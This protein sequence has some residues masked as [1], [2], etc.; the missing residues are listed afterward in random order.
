M[1]PAMT[2]LGI[3]DEPAILRGYG[4]IDPVTAARLTADATSWRRILTDPI[5][6]RILQ[7]SPT[8][9]RPTQE[10]RDHATLVHPYCVFGGCADD[11]VGADI[12]HTR[13]F[14]SGGLTEDENLAP[15]SP[16]HHR[17]KHH[18]RWQIEQGEDNT[19]IWTSPAGLVY[20]F[21]PQGM[22]RAAPRALIDAIEKTTSTE[23]K[24]EEPCPF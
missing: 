5:T 14:D 20:V 16:T 9:Y 19:L 21:E 24:T 2:L 22:M 10:M 6:G 13:D 7:L 1:V 17:V 4:P 8:D 18:T 23:V 11:S 3:G 15:L 12:D